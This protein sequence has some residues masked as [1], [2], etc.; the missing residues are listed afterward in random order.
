[1]TSFPIPPVLV[2]RLGW[3]LVNSLWQF[4]LI[5]LLA[6]VTVRLLRRNSAAVRYGILGA[7][8]VATTVA[9]VATWFVLPREPK[10]ATIVNETAVA[11]SDED[12]SLLAAR[13]E[14]SGEPDV[15]S[16]RG[17]SDVSDGGY[18]ADGA[19]QAPGGVRRSA[20]REVSF[21][22]SKQKADAWWL[23]AADSVRP[24]LPA[25]VF[26]W[27]LGVLL[28]S[29]RPLL[30]WHTL[31]RLR[32]VGVSPVSDEVLATL[33]RVSERLGLRRAVRI[34]YSTLARVP[35]VIGYARPIILLPI[36]LV[37]S[38]PA[39]QLEAIL[40]HEL[41]HVRRH[42]FLVNLLQTLVETA[43]FYHPA[44][45]WLSSRLRAERENCCDDLVVSALGNRVEY[46]RALLAI[47]ELRGRDSLLA[48]GAADGSLLA[49]VRRIVGFQSEMVVGS[50]WSTL[51]LIV[52]GLV[53]VGALSVLSWQSLAESPQAASQP[54]PDDPVAELPDGV[55]TELVG[56]SAPIQPG[57]WPMWGGSSHRNHVASGRMPTQWDL[58][59]GQNVL[60]TAKLGTQTY[61]SPVVSGGKV[62]IGTNNGAGLDPRR[63]AVNDLSCLVC[64]DQATGSLLWQ[65]ASE[66]MPAGTVSDWPGIGLCSTACVEGNRLWVVTNRC[67]VVCLDTDGFRD[68]E[69]D[70][71]FTTE[72]DRTDLDAD[73]VWKFDMFN[74][75][76]VRPL[77]QAAS[78]IAVV[79]GVVLLNTLNGPDESRQN[80]PAPKA[81]NFL[82]LDAR[83]GRVVWQDNSAGESIIAGGFACSW[84]GTSPAVATI[85][86]VAQ[87]IFAGREGWLYGFDFADLKQGKTTR[88]WQFDCN[89]KTSKYFTG[90]QFAR[91]TLVASPVVVGDRVFIATG[92]NPEDGGGEGAGDLWCIDATKRGDISSEQ[93]FNNSHRDG[94]EPIPHKPLC[95]CDPKQGDF[96]R[97]NPNSGAVWHY[98]G[99]DR[100]GDGELAFDET[101]HCSIS[102]PAIHD[103]LLFIP[104]YTGLLH[105]VDARTGEGLWTQDR[106][107]AVWSSCVIADGKV[108]IG[109]ED[110]DLVIFKAARTCQ[111]IHGDNPPN[112]GT[113]IYSTPVVAKGTLLVATRDMLVA[114]SDEQPKAVE[115]GD[116]SAVS[117]R[118]QEE[119]AS[120]DEWGETTI[121]LRARVVPVLSSMS[122]DAIDPAQ[123]VTK[124]QTAEDVAFVVEMENV[125]DAPIKLLDTR[126]GDGYG[127]SKGK[128]NSNW[129]GQFLF[130][131]DLFD[132][133]GK[134]I[135]RPEVQVVDLN[136]VLDKALVVSL[137]PG[138]THRFLLRPAKWLSAM[139][140]R[141]EPGSYRAA[142][143]YH[144]LPD[145]I[146]T[147]I[148]EYRP[149]SS[150]L[151]TVAGGII[152]GQ[153]P[154]EVLGMGI[155]PVAADESLVSG[156]PTNGLRAAMSL[157]P[158]QA[159]YAH[160]E[161]LDTKLHVQNVSE[162][163]ITLASH[164][165]LSELGASVKNDKDESVTVGSTFYSGWTLCSRVT[166]KPRQI[167]TFDAGNIGLA[168][169]KER[170]GKFED[171]TNR[172][173]VAPAGKYTMQLGGRF[174][175]SFLL[176]DGKGK[177]LA[178]LE[179]DW[180]GELKTG[181]MPLAI[182]NEI[183]ECNLVDAVTG[184][185][186]TRASINFRFIKPKSGA[187]DDL[188]TGTIRFSDPR[189]FELEFDYR[190]PNLLLTID[191]QKLE[192]ANGRVFVL[193]KS[194]T[195]KQL[196]IKPPP[197]TDRN[198]VGELKKR[199]DEAI[200]QTQTGAGRGSPDPALDPT[201][202]LPKSDEETNPTNNAN[203]DPR[204]NPA[205]GLGDP[206]RAQ[207][208]TDAVAQ[209]LERIQ[210]IWAMDLC[211]SET[212]DFGDS[213]DVVKQWR[214]AIH[215]NEIKWIRS[216]G[217]VWKLTFAVDPA[218][219]PKEIDFTFLDGPHK[220]E[221][222][223]GMYEW[224]GVNKNMLLMS[225]QDPG[226]TVARPNSIT[227]MGGGQTSLVFLQPVP[228]NETEK[229][230]ASLQGTWKFDIIQTDGWP[231][232][233]GKGPD[234]LG[235]GDERQWVVK[236]N[237]ITWISPAGEEVK[238][239]FTIDPTKAP[240]HIDVT[241]L[242]GPHKGQ[243]CMGMYERGGVGGVV[244]WLCLVD[245][246][247]KA[248]RPTKV[249][250]ETNE[251]RT[252]IGLIRIEPPKNRADN[253]AP[254]IPADESISLADVVRNFNAENKQLGRG[255]DQPALTE[256][257]VLTAIKQS[258]WKRDAPDLNEREVAT[259]KEVAE[260]GRLPK[261]SYLW[262]RTT[263]QHET[264][265]VRNYW[266][267]ELYL[268]A[269]G[270]DGLVG[271]TIRH[272]K[273]PEEKIDPKQVAWGKPDPDRLSLGIYFSPRK[274]KYQVGDRV[275]LRLFVR[276]EGQEAVE[277]MWANTSHPLPNA[278]TVT[279]ES[280]ANVAVRI[281]HESW[282]LPWI[283]GYIDGLAL[284]PGDA[285]AFFVPYEISIGGDGSKNKLIGRVIDARPGQ[286]LQLKVRDSNGNNR[287]RADSEPLPE[288]GVITVVVAKAADPPARP[289][290]E[291]VQSVPPPLEFRFVAQA[292]DS[293]TEPRAPADFAKRDYSGNSVI[294]RTVAKDKGFIWVSVAGNSN[295]IA[296][297]PAE[298]LRGEKV[299]EVLLADTPEHALAWDGKWSVEDCRVVP[300]RSVGP[301]E[302][303]SIEMKLNE[304][305]GNALLAL[306]KA[307]LNQHLAIV[308]DGQIISTPIV[309]GE[310]GRDIAISGN[311]NRAQADKLAKA[312]R[313]PQQPDGDKLKSG[314]NENSTSKLRPGLFG[315][316]A[317][318]MQINPDNSITYNDAKGLC[319]MTLFADDRLQ[320]A[321]HNDNQIWTDVTMPLI[322]GAGRSQRATWSVTSD[323]Y[324][325]QATAMP[326][327]TRGC[328]FRLEKRRDGKLVDGSQQFFAVKSGPANAAAGAEQD[329][330]ATPFKH[331]EWRVDLSGTGVVAGRYTGASQPMQIA[332]DGTISYTDK[333]LSIS[334]LAVLEDDR[335]TAAF[336]DARGMPA[337]VTLPL[338]TT[339]AQ[340]RASW[341]AEIDG[342]TLRVTAIPY[343]DTVYV[344]RLEKLRDG[345]LI[346]GSQ[347]FFAIN[348]KLRP[349]T[350]EE[351]AQAASDSTERPPTEDEVF[352]RWVS[353]QAKEMPLKQ[354]L[355]ELA[356]QAGVELQLDA[357]ALKAVEL[358]VDEPVTASFTDEPLDE[359]LSR[360][361]NWRDHGGAFRE[362]RAGRLVLTTLAARQQ[363]VAGELPEWLRP[364]YTH[365][366]LAAVDDD[367]Q[368]ESI[369][370]GSIATDELLEKLATLPKLRELHIEVTKTLTPAGLKQLGKMQAL[371]TLSLY[372]VNSEGN[373]LGD[374]AM[375]AVA[376]LQSLREV[377]VNNCGLTDAGARHLEGL[378]QLTRLVL[379]EG[380]LTDAALASIGKLQHLQH[381]S[382]SNYV[383]TVQYGRMH[384]TAAGL[385]SLAGLRELDELHL[386]GQDVSADLLTWP[387]LTA[388]SLGGA[389]VD[390]ACAERIA[391]CR[392]L[393][394][395]SLV[396]TAV[397]DEGIKQIATLPALRRLNLD[398][399]VITDA[400]M[401]HLKAVTSLQML[402]LRTTRLTDESLR[403]M[404]EMQSL[405]RLD[406]HG[407]G[408]PGFAPGEN[409]SINALRQLKALPKLHALWLT[410]F[411]SSGGYLGL[412]DLTQLREL[413]LMMAD[414]RTEDLD[415]L[416]AA[417][418]NTTIHCASGGG[419]RRPITKRGRE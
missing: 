8:L 81:P 152:A 313:P 80:V 113:S 181:D 223:L 322:Q 371:D 175:D 390:D 141:I 131:I 363:R 77:H 120:Q 56:G 94:R 368:V 225:V 199:I 406:L 388:L 159:K 170:A 53:V 245:P 396:Y 110:G 164:L 158:S 67:E 122:E 335:L 364:L 370:I 129:Y 394:S 117:G 247:S 23:L 65:Y 330:P 246:S 204:S 24:W 219:S 355:A 296:A 183:I 334:P 346:E 126:Y 377:R 281:G 171:V 255:L 244:L 61:S 9:P 293:K 201:A 393:K 317:Q 196:A 383:G 303:F 12:I 237:E 168:V 319:Q 413:S 340:H 402:T 318:L 418:P 350:P 139:T 148:K 215:E 337:D 375:Q 416:E 64:F 336:R 272:T 356:R 327:S 37:T 224:G 404:A 280:G 338:V 109:D 38:I 140:Q 104:D 309:Y 48:I 93:V 217:E 179:G 256:D 398:S 154:F 197:V 194:G 376:G 192:L 410:N 149:D 71:E 412:A 221:K 326:F 66:K 395:L 1:M 100:D 329:A 316:F 290:N 314:S 163:P 229:E 208:F 361:I 241:F 36:S 123:R 261:G 160:G 46:G 83:T 55:N 235:R 323:G 405:R 238:L 11:P 73:V 391:A 266:L 138:K 240:K 341:S 200:R 270:H 130:S 185:P 127:E 220:G 5:G 367:G 153:V 133:D 102:S 119:R 202:D 105:C 274:D 95:A 372:E 51:S 291:G 205:A 362:F 351:K 378:P 78:S 18:I 347:Q 297:L 41:A 282:E 14:P 111:P 209:E 19:D 59:T 236:G 285:H 212:K 276:N 277:T 146:A 134:L 90:G 365:G 271:F 2:E 135:E 101:F 180:I 353:L 54:K 419:S 257:E 112:F 227:M 63:P 50:P 162:G 284:G 165:W 324:T 74:T 311:F 401:E 302:H 114:I 254:A 172:T 275:R 358:D 301:V 177:V 369:T 234:R 151:E 184:Q 248:P 206:R 44:V 242:S 173:L 357:E 157:V 144:G 349:A 392:E 385:R 98:A 25:F 116:A 252:M 216:G 331:R 20:T 287:T 13:R 348:Q 57:E 198:R 31:R 167:V 239:S 32:R 354:A 263:D 253:P 118:G 49:R 250:Y 191:G 21:P 226:A 42:D 89:P 286:T 328:L 62:F 315:G 86:G 325:Y 103:G 6:A 128:A 231:K 352:A 45:W 150:V 386:V 300:A 85:G 306:T 233:T 308:V 273:L 87:A 283:S 169:T 344:F 307:H 342:H 382:L 189:R 108:L 155:P 132:V 264:F 408:Q 99:T 17:P 28:C 269:I 161:K 107:A 79:D 27:S 374:E 288:S 310:F 373:G 33:R 312:I 304:A 222:C 26:A 182:T 7:A 47:E 265:L 15:A 339:A 259:F 76:G 190:P 88:L 68:G 366:L 52:C 278:F 34:M 4:V 187:S 30:G 397:S 91:N 399:R 295:E 403:H 147:R 211:D 142:V 258:D 186:V 214:W 35:I 43:F 97:P 188:K 249:S 343:S 320:V 176:K 232:P 121:G 345:K 321:F 10:P 384:F 92:R 262:V 411:R 379:D 213:Q 415:A 298:R 407:S 115:Q 58:K 3:V 60:W 333:P 292:A 409:F 143:T 124:F 251:G 84:S 75:L 96:T 137:E 230:L 39:A 72:T 387:K 360:L 228:A 267:I 279:D 195:T 210:G 166:L 203:G 268:P 294:G 260:S 145:R 243:K 389:T 359:A 156:E 22:K 70:G 380:R 218:K 381:L 207:I 332:A 417:L 125:S 16:R 82:A 40:A 289:E 414:I 106:L 299:R 69:N 193:S 29:L 136:S 174:G 400:A 305:G 178:P